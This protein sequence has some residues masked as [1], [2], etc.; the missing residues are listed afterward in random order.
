MAMHDA[1]YLRELRAICDRQQ[2]HLI[3]DEIAVGCGRTGSFFACEQA[4]VWPDFICLSKGISGGYLPLSIVLSRDVIYNAFNDDAPVRSFL[5]SHSYTGNPLAC[6][7]ALATRDLFAE[8]DVFA[9][10]R[11]TAARIAQGLAPLSH[12]ARFAHLRQ[13]G[14]ITAF[15]VHPDVA[16]ARFAE[17]FAL[18]ARTHG[19]LLRPIGNTVYLLPPY[20]LSDEETDTLVERTLQTLEDTLAQATGET[21]GHTYAIA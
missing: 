20:V 21:E 10:N 9:R 18:T 12:D 8:E 14:M 13:T 6:R 2:V 17:R 1:Q 5:H 7:A 15:D 16:G 4:G 11:V 19:L 3:A